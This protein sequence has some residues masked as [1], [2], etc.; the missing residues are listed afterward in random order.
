MGQ[1]S[2]QAGFLVGQCVFLAVAIYLDR[3]TNPVFKPWVA[4]F[5]LAT[6]VAIAPATFACVS[7]SGPLAWNGTLS[8][9]L[10][11]VASFSWLV[12]MMFVVGKNLYA[13]R[14]R[15]DGHARRH[16]EGFAR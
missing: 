13:Q 9:W 6:A 2:A 12:V 4:H 8:F 15:P 10:K 16:E 1:L 5:S 14:G 11:N 3:Q 7:L